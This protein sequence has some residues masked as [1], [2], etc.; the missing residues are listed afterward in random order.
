MD[1]DMMSN[2]EICSILVSEGYDPYYN[3]A[4]EEELLYQVNKYGCIL[5]L[6]QNSPSVIIGYNH[7]PW[8]EC[9]VDVLKEDEGIL[10]RRLSGGGAVYHDL[11]NLNFSFISPKKY[12][13]ISKQLEVIQ[14]AVVSFG[15]LPVRSGRNDLLIGNRKF[16]GYAYYNNGECSLHHGTILV[17][18]NNEKLVRYLNVSTA[19]LNSK[20]IQSVKS[21]ICNLCEFEP[22]ITIPEMKTHIIDSYKELFCISPV[23][24]VLEDL[25][26]QNLKR[27][28]AK[29]SSW[30]WIFG[31]GIPFN[32]EFSFRCLWGEITAQLMINEGVVQ[33][34]AIWSDSLDVNIS[35]RLE[36]LLI[37]EP[38]NEKE[39]KEKIHR[40]VTYSL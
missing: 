38:F 26:V 12:T 11:G 6:W 23:Q 32:Y 40:F 35:P 4:I 16:S 31:R 20:G 24:I 37:G 14:R 10:T 27:R 7:N 1:F 33:D 2:R 15:L 39:I 8:M 36:K 30:Q 19:K 22:S 3:F 17:N 9:N 29:F 25:D 18:V 21:R 28:Q 34:I 5:F 13:N